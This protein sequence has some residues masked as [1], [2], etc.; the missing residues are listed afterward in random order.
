MQG[1]FERVRY[2]VE[3]E[4]VDINQKN[5]FDAIPLFYACLCGHSGKQVRIVSLAHLLE[6]VKYLLS[7][8]AVLEANTFEAE[9]CYY[10]ALN[11]EITRLLREFKGMY[12]TSF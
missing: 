4:D 12:I 8:G 2:L 5:E 1:N 6:L 9:R 11:D 3:E 10:G 7:K